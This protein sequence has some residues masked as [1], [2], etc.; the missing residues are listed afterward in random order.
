MTAQSKVWAVL[1]VVFALGCVTGASLGGLF[2]AGS[3]SMAVPSMRD[4]EA[5]FATLKQE[6]SL[7]EQQSS[8]IHA[9]LDETREEYKNVCA[10]VRPRYDRLRERARAR[11]RELLEPA[12]QQRFDSMV[13]Q[14]DCA[15]CPMQKR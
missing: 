8:R 15:T 3:G 4:S 10:E 11:V 5:Y 13:S 7:S 9:I 12:Q 2:R 6:L 1:V 14:E